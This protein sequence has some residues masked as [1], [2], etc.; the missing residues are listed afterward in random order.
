MDH[1]N[2][3]TGKDSG[4]SST[5]MDFTQLFQA[6]DEVIERGDSSCQRNEKGH[7]EISINEDDSTFEKLLEALFSLGPDCK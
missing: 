1:I 3:D 5:L 4:G 7:Q 6:V 2:S